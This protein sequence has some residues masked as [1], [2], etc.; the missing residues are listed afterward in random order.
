MWSLHQTYWW[1][2]E[3]L[4]VGVS[5]LQ[6]SGWLK[7]DGMFAVSGKTLS[8]PQIISFDLQENGVKPE[9]LLSFPYPGSTST[10]TSRTF[11]HI[12]AF[13]LFP[14]MINIS[15]QTIVLAE[16]RVLLR[17][18]TKMSQWKSPNCVTGVQRH[19]LTCTASC[20]HT[21]LSSGRHHQTKRDE[22]W[23]CLTLPCTKMIC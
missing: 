11:A 10:E 19:E 3:L 20:W 2:T 16:Y 7:L 8:I 14:A 21:F 13:G 22:D 23:C 17:V 4:D 15:K 5:W 18:K 6:N 1:H 9:A 12:K